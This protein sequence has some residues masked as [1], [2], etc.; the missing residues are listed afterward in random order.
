MLFRSESH[1]YPVSSE[2]TVTGS[3]TA[4]QIRITACPLFDD[5]NTSTD[6]LTL[7]DAKGLVSNSLSITVTRPAGDP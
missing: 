1:V 6:T 3:S 7:I 2:A 5:G 4:G